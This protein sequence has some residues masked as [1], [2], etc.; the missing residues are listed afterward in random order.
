[1]SPIDILFVFVSGIILYISLNNCIEP[2]FNNVFTFLSMLKKIDDKFGMNML[3]STLLGKK[4]TKDYLK[5]MDEFGKG[6]TLGNEDWWKL[7]SRLLLNE[8]LIIEKQLTGLYGS[9]ISVTS[10]GNLLINELKNKY[11]NYSE[12]ILDNDSK[13]CLLQEIIVITQ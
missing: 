8:D 9:T 2:S 4:Q 1:M 3:I 10:K 13:N 11:S 7:F 6:I 12:I 5:K